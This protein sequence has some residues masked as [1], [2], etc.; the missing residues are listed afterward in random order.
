MSSIQ[1]NMILV[2][3]FL[4]NL[5][6]FERVYA[7]QNKIERIINDQRQYVEF[8]EVKYLYYLLHARAYTSPLI[9]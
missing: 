7:Y 1:N 8:R 4:Y 9:K 6:L 5:I 3:Y 2:R